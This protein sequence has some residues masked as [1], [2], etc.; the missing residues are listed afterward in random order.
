MRF[1]ELERN[2]DS[3]IRSSTRNR[4]ELAQFVHRPIFKHVPYPLL[5]DPPLSQNL[6]SLQHVI[7]SLNI[8]DDPYVI[9]LRK[10]LTRPLTDAQR[11]RVDQKLSKAIRRS[12]TFT[13]KG[14]QDLERAAVDIWQDLGWWAADWFV[15]TVIERAIAASTVHSGIM[16]SWQDRERAY[17]L[18][19]LERI[20]PIPYSEDPS[21]IMAGLSPKVR[22]LLD[23]LQE[24]ERNYRTQE[25]PFSGII[26]VKRRDVVIA[27]GEIL[28]R[29][30]AMRQHFQ[31]GCLL[32][33][34]SSTQRHA[35]LDITRTLL[36]QTASET[37]RDF[38]IG[39]KNIVVS[40]SVAEEGIDIQACGCVIRFDPPDN[41][42]AWAQSRG[43]ARRRRSTFILMLDPDSI[44]DNK[45]AQW[46]QTEQEMI[47]QYTDTGRAREEQNDQKTDEDDL[48]Y[49]VEETG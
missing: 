8:E 5:K 49:M 12:D 1:R 37:L 16:G 42:V 14:L 7:A 19:N 46:E 34:S 38:S 13:H 45:I 43:R 47:T 3:I 26:F 6:L 28:S 44:A 2:L 36:K 48:Q 23:C 10:Q 4:D 39:D 24:E 27:L 29:L 9:S 11:H 35:F 41:M 21:E 32:G 33:A 40:T 30:P 18:K 22:I 20:K 15:V 31:V 25:E 17:L